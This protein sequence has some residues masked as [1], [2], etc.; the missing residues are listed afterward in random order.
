MADGKWGMANAHRQFAQAAKILMDSRGEFRTEAHGQGPCAPGASWSYPGGFCVPTSPQTG[1][2]PSCL[3][4]FFASK[5]APGA[6][7]TLSV[8]SVLAWEGPTTDRT[9]CFASPVHPVCI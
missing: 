3:G 9:I 6:S 7:P 1:A 4:G 5:G 8:V 2:S